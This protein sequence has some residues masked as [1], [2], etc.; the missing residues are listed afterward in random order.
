[1]RSIDSHALYLDLLEDLGFSYDQDLTIYPWDN[2]SL[3]AKKALAISFVKKYHGDKMNEAAS[4]RAY[5][6]FCAVN[7]RCKT[8]QLH[9]ETL[10][11]EMLVGTFRKYLHAFFSR[12]NGEPLVHSFS[13]ILD[14]GATGPGASIGAE[15]TDF[16]TKLFDSCLSTTSNGLYRAYATYTDTYPLWQE[17]EQFRRKAWGD[18]SIA[19]GNRLSFVPKDAQTARTICIEPNLNMFYQLGL[20]R[21][22]EERLRGFFHIDLALQPIANRTLAERG[23]CGNGLVTIDLSSAS[24]SMS[25]AMMKEFLPPEIFQWCDILRSKRYSFRSSSGELNMLSTMGNGFTFPLQTALFSCVVAAAFEVDSLLMR[26][27]TLFVDDQL[28]PSTNWGVF[29]DDII[30]PDIISDKVLRL[31]HI[32]GFVVN[33]EKTFTGQFLFRESCGHDFFMSHFVRG[34]Y[35]K[36]LRKPQNRYTLINRLN[37]WSSHQGIPLVRTM[38]SLL[39][40]VPRIA[41]PPW[42]NDDCGIWTPSR[43]L[44]ILEPSNVRRVYGG[45][46]LFR[47]YRPNPKCIR[48]S[49]DS[50][51]IHVPRREKPRRYNPAGLYLAFLRGSISNGKIMIRPDH[52]RYTTK[53]VV[54]PNW[55]YHSTVKN[56]FKGSF[57]GTGLNTPEF[58]NLMNAW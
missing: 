21:I 10:L 30:C 42:E 3:V 15:S 46:Y 25:Y 34:V 18:V 20:G 55:D 8:W 26:V 57:G 12:K 56:P 43:A 52:V 6:K 32:L 36:T 35:C 4:K 47:C 44:S 23:S 45:S 22:I 53:R 37:E 11:D 51:I 7:D 17:A 5:D 1:M 31:L 2:S 40:T 49:Q 24:D 54:A 39:S 14:E 28:H 13:S 27:D 33:H 19:A 29:G 38:R 9:V 16:Y 41:V 50:E 48:I 58:I